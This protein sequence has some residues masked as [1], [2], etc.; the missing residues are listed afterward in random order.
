[1]EQVVEKTEVIEEI[2]DE[3]NEVTE[4]TVFELEEKEPETET[5]VV[6]VYNLRISFN[7]TTVTNKED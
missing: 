1:M 7:E 5:I 6:T 3:V 4:D 2:T